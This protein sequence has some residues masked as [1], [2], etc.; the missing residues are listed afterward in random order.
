MNKSPVTKTSVNG[1]EI[2]S[3]I[4]SEQ[5]PKELYSLN[6]E[7]SEIPQELID[8]CEKISQ[9]S[10]ETY[11]IFDSTNTNTINYKFA[12]SKEEKRDVLL[13]EIIGDN[14]KYHIGSEKYFTELPSRFAYYDTETKLC[15]RYQ[16]HNFV[17][18]FLKKLG[19]ICESSFGPELEQSFVYNLDYE[20]STFKVIIRLRPNLFLNIHISH[21]NNKNRSGE[22]SNCYDGFFNKSKILKILEKNCPIIYK[23]ILRDFKLE[24]IL[25]QEN[26]K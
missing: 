7:R 25:N 5:K 23:S 24:E 16:R 2:L 13:D 17:V 12:F 19:F 15:D 3:C 4:G 1:I 9:E 18:N 6:Y 21:V 22:A 14:N 8:Q 11:F 26:L 10:E 20:D